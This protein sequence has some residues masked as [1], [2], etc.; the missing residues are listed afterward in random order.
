MRI[1]GCVHVS[2]VFSLPTHDLPVAREREEWRQQNKALKSRHRDLKTLL[3]YLWEHKYAPR[4]ARVRFA[5][6]CH[7]S[8]SSDSDTSTTVLVDGESADGQP[9]LA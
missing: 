4:R 5:D 8:A 1:P 7:L 6:E 3:D 2:R 9:G